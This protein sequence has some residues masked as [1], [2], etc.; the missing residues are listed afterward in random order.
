VSYRLWCGFVNLYRATE[1]ARLFCLSMVIVHCIIETSTVMK[2]WVYD[3]VMFL[4]SP[5]EVTTRKIKVI[6]MH[7]LP[8]TKTAPKIASMVHMIHFP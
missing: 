7:E 5:V 2:E 4:A 1:Y 8:W 6:L 3:H